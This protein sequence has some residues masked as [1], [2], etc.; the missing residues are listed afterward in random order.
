MS[1]CARILSRLRVA[2]LTA[3]EALSELSV[4]RL[5]A[6]VDELRQHGHDIRTEMVDALNVFGEG[7]RYGRY[8]LVKEAI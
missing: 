6:R 4:G 1:Q 5:A 8:H 3:A 2:P 7:C